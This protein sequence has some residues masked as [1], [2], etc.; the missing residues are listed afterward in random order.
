MKTWGILL[1][2]TSIFIP[3]LFLNSTQAGET[4]GSLNIIVEGFTDSEGYVMVA[5]FGSEKAYDEGSPKTVKA[6]VKVEAQKALAAFIDLKYG[7]YA[8]AVFHD[9][10]ANKKMDKNFLGIPKESY[11]HSNNVRGSFGPPS[12]DKA[13]FKFGSSG[14]QIKIMLD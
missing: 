7:I 11:G 1:L 13:K 9:R 10:N 8:V 12:F 2:L 5:V 4:S 6:R 14:K 3:A